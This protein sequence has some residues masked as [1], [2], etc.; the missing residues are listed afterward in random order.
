VTELEVR[1]FKVEGDR[2]KAQVA[3]AG[4]QSFGD[5]RYTLDLEID[6]PLEK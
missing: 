6:A 4:E 3:T 5:D 2:L 1:S